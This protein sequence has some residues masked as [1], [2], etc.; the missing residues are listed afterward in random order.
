MKLRIPIFTMLAA[1]VLLM[2]VSALNAQEDPTPT[3]L[4][5]DILVPVPPPS[6]TVEGIDLGAVPLGQTSDFELNSESEASNQVAYEI[7][8]NKDDPLCDT[9]F[10]GYLNLE[11]INIFPWLGVEGNNVAW[12]PFFTDVGPIQFFGKRYDEMW[13]TDDGIIIFDVHNNYHR[14]WTPQMI[15]DPALPNNIL[16]PLWQDMT[17]VEDR[18]TNRGVSAAKAVDGSV[19]VLEFDDVHLANAPNQRY[20]FEIIMQ[21]KVSNKKGVY[22]IVFAYDNLKGALDGPLTVGVENWSGDNAASFVNNSDATGIL[23][24]GLIVCFNAVTGQ[25]PQEAPDDVQASDGDHPDKVLV[26]W[27]DV[28]EAEGYEIFRSESVDGDQYKIGSS[29]NTNFQDMTAEPG[30]AYAYWVT[31]C[32]TYGCSEYSEHDIG[33]R[34]ENDEEGF[35]FMRFFPLVNSLNQ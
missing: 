7:T 30:T 19:L 13:I 27:G 4:S 18:K 21:R 16:A 35:D 12:G 2:V 15:A 20:D 1:I 26:S 33:W 22:E 32:N 23:E 28:E 10:D 6:M 8:T 17:I 14:S 9:G 29:D 3:K 34:A 25:P 24:D 11:D 31:T 5:K